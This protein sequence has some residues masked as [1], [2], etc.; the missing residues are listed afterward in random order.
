M[1]VITEQ[2]GI[3]LSTEIFRNPEQTATPGAK[4]DLVWIYTINDTE[5]LSYKFYGLDIINLHTHIRLFT[6][7]W[8]VGI[9]N[10]NYINIKKKQFTCNNFNV[11]F[12]KM[13][14]IDLPIDLCF[15]SEISFVNR[16][17]KSIKK[18]TSV[19][20]FVRTDG[21]NIVVQKQLL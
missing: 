14:K 7:V 11:L 3:S 10:E 2:P 4:F 8:S 13:S 17:E 21:Y 6:F 18:K 12:I 19:S 20:V 9:S 5:R 15:F 16:P 1:N